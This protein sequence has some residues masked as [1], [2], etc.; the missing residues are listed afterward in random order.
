MNRYRVRCTVF[1]N[2][3][4]FYE[5][6]Y[7]FLGCQPPVQ[8]HDRGR[9]IVISRISEIIDVGINDNEKTRC[10]FGG[11]GFYYLRQD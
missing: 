10:C 5:K 6:A 7:A 3:F 11:E 1:S 9:P 8:G 2:F 4:L